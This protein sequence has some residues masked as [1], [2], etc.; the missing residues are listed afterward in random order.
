MCEIEAT[1]EF[2][3]FVAISPNSGELALPA[4]DLVPVLDQAEAAFNDTVHDEE[5]DW[6]L[7]KRPLQATLQLLQTDY[8]EE[9]TEMVKALQHHDM[10]HLIGLLRWPGVATRF[11]KL[12]AWYITLAVDTRPSEPRAVFAAFARHLGRVTSYRALALH[13]KQ[14]QALFD[15]NEIFPSGQ[16][17]VSAS[18]LADIVE[19]HGVRKIAVLRL[20]I[21][22]LRRN[23]GH[24][25]SVSLHDDWQTTTAIAAG[26]AS[27][28]KLDPERSKA[29]HLFEMSVP[30]IE[31]LGW[32]LIDVAARA[33]PIL[34]PSYADHKRFFCFK[35]PAAE[36]GIWFDAEDQRTE[37]YSLYTLPF[38]AQRLQSHRV[39]NSFEV[40]RDAIAPFTEHQ[41]LL[42]QSTPE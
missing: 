13:P 28:D 3:E 36:D 7:S 19:V 22:H 14:A 10:A 21:A 2:Q 42:W 31:S 34:G 30:V 12:I 27:F 39:F 24:D 18:D 6:M 38:L 20:Y 40:I 41:R 29:V 32:R 11:K 8:G 15:A 25:P 5:I 1:T 9:A 23:I 17:K 4:N 33:G 35:T 16:L 37:R 26:Y